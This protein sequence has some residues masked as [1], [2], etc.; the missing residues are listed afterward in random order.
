MSISENFNA[1]VEAAHTLALRLLA[2]HG[3]S[4][5]S[6]R[7]NRSKR[8]L[9]RCVYSRHTIELSVHFVARNNEAEILD[10]LLHEIAHALVGPGH[11]HDRVWKSKCLELGAQPRACVAADMPTGRWRA[12]CGS[13]GAQFHRHRR[14]RT[15]TGW[16]CRRCGPTSGALTWTHGG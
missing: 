6:F 3:L 1:R 2:E 16:H 10:T 8:T 5:W 15:L 13:C 4:D 9:G 12:S 11:G 14:P 7:L